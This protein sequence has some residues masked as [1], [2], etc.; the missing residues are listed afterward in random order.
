MEEV[1]RKDQDEMERAS[2]A[3]KELKFQRDDFQM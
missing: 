2:E 3:L 1:R